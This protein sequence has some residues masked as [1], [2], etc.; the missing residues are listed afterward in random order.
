MKKILNLVLF[1]GLLGLLICTSSCKKKPVRISV[2]RNKAN[3]KYEDADLKNRES[4]ANNLKSDR[5]NLKVSSNSNDA[6]FGAEDDFSSAP[7]SLP[8]KDLSGQEANLEGR[9]NYVKSLKEDESDRSESEIVNNCF[10]ATSSQYSENINELELSE[11]VRQREAKLSDIPAPINS[12]P[13]AKYFISQ[14]NNSDNN[15]GVGLAGCSFGQKGAERSGV[16]NVGSC[17]GNGRQ[18]VLGYKSRMDIDSVVKFYN[19]E[20]EMYGWQ[21]LSLFDG[22]EKLMIF[23]KPSRICSV[24]L[25]VIGGKG[26]GIFKKGSCDFKCEV[27]IFAKS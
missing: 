2:N 10:E 8:N 20:M 5:E 6:V 27:I 9:E 19:Q 15:F 1:I 11:L 18:I 12:E 26:F 17:K 13:I 25:R 16:G 22:L 7:F 21:V 14:V 4:G 23:K 3:L 24:S